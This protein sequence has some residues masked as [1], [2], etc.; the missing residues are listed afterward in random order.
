MMAH[1]GSLT[2]KTVV[3]TRVVDKV[4]GGSLALMLLLLVRFGIGGNL[5]KVHLQDV[6]LPRNHTQTV[7]IATYNNEYSSYV[8]LDAY[9]RVSLENL[10]SWT[11]SE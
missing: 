9:L 6:V 10:I 3:V 2:S 4:G 1:D 8:A 11:T 5:R 7:K